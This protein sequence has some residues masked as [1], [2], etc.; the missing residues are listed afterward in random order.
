MSA[1]SRLAHGD[2]QRVH[3][4]ENRTR[5]LVKRPTAQHGGARMERDGCVTISVA[6]VFIF[7]ILENA[8]I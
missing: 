4:G 7:I 6:L 1:E 2:R 8:R 5:R 3:A